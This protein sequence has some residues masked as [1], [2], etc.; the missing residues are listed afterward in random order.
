M[1]TQMTS[2]AF[3]LSPVVKKNVQ[4]WSNYVSIAFLHSDRHKQEVI[5]NREFDG[6]FLPQWWRHMSRDVC[7]GVGCGECGEV[8]EGGTELFHSMVRSSD[9][10]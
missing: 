10:V 4:L 2:D 8:G 5:E 3:A 7:G 9:D 6:L 1:R